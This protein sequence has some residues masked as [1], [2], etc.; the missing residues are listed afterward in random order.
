MLFQPCSLLDFASS[1]TLTLLYTG[2]EKSQKKNQ[3]KLKILSKIS[4]GGDSTEST[5]KVSAA[6]RLIDA[7]Q[8]NPSGEYRSSGKIERRNSA[9]TQLIQ[10]AGI[11]MKAGFTAN[12]QLRGPC[13]RTR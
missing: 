3:E 13:D 5:G 12:G 9:F 11:L 10:F 4:S 2:A 7:V 1:R 6:R 8:Q